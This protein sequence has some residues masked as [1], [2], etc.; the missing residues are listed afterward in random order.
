MVCMALALFLPVITFGQFGPK[1]TCRAVVVGISEYQDPDIPDLRFAHNDAAAFATYLQ[2]RPV[3]QV[4][5]ENLKLLIN[6]HATGGN[7][8]SA[9]RSLVQDSKTGDKVVIYFAG[10]GDV[11][12]LFPDEPGHL[13]VFD[14]PANNYSSNSL[15]L[16]DIRRTVNALVNR[17]IQVLI[18]T[19][20]CHAGK[21]AGS[22]VKVRSRVPRRICSIST[23]VVSTVSSSVKSSMAR[24]P[25][26]EGGNSPLLIA[27]AFLNT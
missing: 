1:G 8:H 5:S 10:H 19:D 18:V 20:A 24:A 3:D 26:A 22:A 14:T 4:S 13:L 6:E 12:T 15:R 7:V 17:E 23:G 11:E 25:K 9:L 27:S 21:L 2:K 16:D